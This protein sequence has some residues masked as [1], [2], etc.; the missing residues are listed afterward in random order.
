MS[1][2]ALGNYVI[3]KVSPKEKKKG[4]IHLPDSA[5]EGNEDFA[6]VMSV[7]PLCE[8]GLMLGDLVLCP[9]CGDIEWTDEDDNDQ[10]YYLIEETA[11]AARVSR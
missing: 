2:E 11:I 5:V 8:G 6:E 10:V 7:G 9:E 4:T 1:L 3:L